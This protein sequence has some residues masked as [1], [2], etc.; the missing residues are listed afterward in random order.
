M[1]S[2][3]L[4]GDTGSPG[5]KGEIGYQ[6]LKGDK[7]DTG[8]TGAKGEIGLKGD[9]GDKGKANIPKVCTEYPEIFVVCNFTVFA[10]FTLHYINSAIRG[11]HIQYTETFGQILSWVKSYIVSSLT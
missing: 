10:T 5:P 6:G 1:L 8:S 11:Y 9:T 7:G 3:G 4:K 2:K